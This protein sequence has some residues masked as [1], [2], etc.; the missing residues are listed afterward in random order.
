MAFCVEQN[1]IYQGVEAGKNV[2]TLV[3][4]L[5]SSFSVKMSYKNKESLV[6]KLIQT[7]LKFP[8]VCSIG[9]S[10]DYFMY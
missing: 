8:V 4:F 2:C 3:P 10:A 5:G 9:V 1:G 7:D 6:F